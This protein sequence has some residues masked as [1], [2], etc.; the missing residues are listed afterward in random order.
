MDLNTLS[1]IGKSAD[2][3]Y[4][5]YYQLKD[6][7][8]YVEAGAFIGRFITKII[9]K[10]QTGIS[11]SAVDIQE[12]INIHLKKTV[13]IEPC[14]YSAN[15]LDEVI[16]EGVVENG[17]LVKKAITNERKKNA[18]F[19]NWSENW[20][21]SRLA[22]HDNDTVESHIDIETDSLDNILDDIG[23]K[24]ENINLLC[25]DV[26][27]AEVELIKGAKRHLEKGLIKNIAICTYHN[28]PENHNLI[29]SILW[30]YGFSKI[31][32]EAGITFAKL[33]DCCKHCNSDVSKFSRFDT[34]KGV[35]E[36]RTLKLDD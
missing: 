32:Y 16:K 35:D 25:A 7:D 15:I 26:E 17:C 24:N 28:E 31:K 10:Q 14:P 6:D 11:H 19:I 8:I 23:L 36:V 29:S 33:G 13:L 22:H 2:H 27:G 1:L 18:K 21:S 30:K 3:N 9:R 34:I 4:C 20:N 12:S 5:L